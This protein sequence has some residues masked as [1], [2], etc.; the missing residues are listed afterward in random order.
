M[1]LKKWVRRSA[2]VCV[3]F[4]KMWLLRSVFEA[5]T[6]QVLYMAT[7]GAF[8][9]GARQGHESC[10]EPGKTA[11]HGLGQF[12]QEPLAKAVGKSARPLLARD[13]K[14]ACSD[15]VAFST[16]SSHCY[17]AIGLCFYIFRG[18]KY[19]GD[20]HPQFRN[21]GS[22]SSPK[23]VSFSSVSSKPKKSEKRLPRHQKNN[24]KRLRNP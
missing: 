4:C 6:H 19:L 9:I 23:I 24:T 14:A 11:V 13:T 10:P 15:T 18:P 2:A 1:F 20:Y 16:I 3:F 5:T 21:S 8:T 22:V 12:E 7:N 17:S